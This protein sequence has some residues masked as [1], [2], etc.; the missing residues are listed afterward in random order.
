MG[1][2]KGDENIVAMYVNCVEHWRAWCFLVGSPGLL[3][4]VGGA[5]AAPTVVDTCVQCV[6]DNWFPS[7]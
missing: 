1:A 5:V 6:C 3:L 4:S 2:K 7:G